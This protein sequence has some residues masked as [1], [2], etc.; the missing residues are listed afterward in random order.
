MSLI[1]LNS[2]F[3][4]YNAARHSVRE[5]DMIYI[6][7]ELYYSQ[8]TIHATLR[9]IRHGFSKKKSYHKPFL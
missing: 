6:H 4:M 1:K 2:Y 5:F 7:D 8:H 3:L 9:S